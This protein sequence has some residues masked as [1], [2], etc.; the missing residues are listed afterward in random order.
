VDGGADVSACTFGAGKP[1]F[2]V[3]GG[4]PKA[5][6]HMRFLMGW[7]AFYDMITRLADPAKQTP[8]WLLEIP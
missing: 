3:F 4:R 2:A 1:C 8:T 5:F 7:K 6:R